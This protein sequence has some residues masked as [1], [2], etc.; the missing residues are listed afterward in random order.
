MIENWDARLSLAMINLHKEFFNFQG[1]LKSEYSDYTACPVCFSDK[2]QEYAV[3]D[4]F[5]YKK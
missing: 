2:Y 5:E 4:K 3:K 1:E